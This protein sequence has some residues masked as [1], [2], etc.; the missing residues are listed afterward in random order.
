VNDT[1]ARLD[2]QGMCSQSKILQ[3]LQCLR[4]DEGESRLPDG[5]DIGEVGEARWR[6]RYVENDGVLGEL[7]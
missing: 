6:Y 7:V 3:L 2:S 4:L 5:S 1:L